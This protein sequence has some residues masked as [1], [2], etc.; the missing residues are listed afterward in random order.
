MMTRTLRL[1]TTA[2]EIYLKIGTAKNKRVAGPGHVFFSEDVILPYYR[3]N[4]VKQVE[5]S[6]LRLNSS[7][8]ID[9]GTVETEMKYFSLDKQKRPKARVR[10]VE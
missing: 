10:E 1:H 8:E 3:L 5:E 2:G 6:N 4:T 9:G 7:K